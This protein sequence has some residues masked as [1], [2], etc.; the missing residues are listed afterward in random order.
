MKDFILALWGRWFG[1][2]LAPLT[3]K[4]TD[5][6]DFIADTVPPESASYVSAGPVAIKTFAPTSDISPR[7]TVHAWGDRSG[8]YYIVDESVGEHV[9]SYA[10]KRG[11]V[12]AAKRMN[13]VGK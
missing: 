9:R 8:R 3:S 6:D 10:H 13:E 2:N 4:W 5:L 1:L 7:Y 12:A 11:A